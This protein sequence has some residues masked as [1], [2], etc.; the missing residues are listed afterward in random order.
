MARNGAATEMPA[1]ETS[2]TGLTS[3]S[4]AQTSH[5]SL[6][7]GVPVPTPSLH[8]P[9][10]TMVAGLETELQVLVEALVEALLEELVEELV[11]VPL[12]PRTRARTEKAMIML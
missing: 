11:E 4:A 12:S 9:A 6:A 5:T 10:L 1:T 3:M 2:S 7:A 8:L